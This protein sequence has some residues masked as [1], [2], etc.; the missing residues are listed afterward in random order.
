MHFLDRR[1]NKI[2]LEIAYQ[3]RAQKYLVSVSWSVIMIVV[4]NLVLNIVGRETNGFRIT[5]K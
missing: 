4:S 5:V 1:R 2:G 3:H